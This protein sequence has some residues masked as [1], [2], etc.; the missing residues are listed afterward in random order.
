MAPEMPFVPT[1]FKFP[2]IANLFM[3]L[4]SASWRW[5]LALLKFN[6]SHERWIIKDLFFSDARLQ[7]NVGRPQCTEILYHFVFF[8]AFRWETCGWSDC[9][10]V[11]FYEEICCPNF[12]IFLCF[13]QKFL[14]I[15]PLFTEPVGSKN[16]STI[17]FFSLRVSSFVNRSLL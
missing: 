3:K 7:E 4:Q 17:F 8:V 12:S 9:F 16:M 1:G 2:D 5:Q 13:G 10:Q 6:S 11:T 15:N 14:I